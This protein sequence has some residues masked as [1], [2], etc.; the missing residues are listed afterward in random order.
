MIRVKPILIY[1]EYKKKYELR[2]VQFFIFIRNIKN[3]KSQTDF[4]L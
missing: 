1:K 3:D 2:W 4:N